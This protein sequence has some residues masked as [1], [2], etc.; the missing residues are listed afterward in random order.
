MSLNFE[1]IKGF[2]V[3][4]LNRIHLVIEDSAKNEARRGREI[5]TSQDTFPVFNEYIG[6]DVGKN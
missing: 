4:I 2:T 5:E 6:K 1:L 3:C